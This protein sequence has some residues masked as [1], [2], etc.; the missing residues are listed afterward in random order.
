MNT[1]LIAHSTNSEGLEHSLRSHLKNVSDVMAVFAENPLYED[2]FRLTGLLHDIGKYQIAFQKYLREGGKRGSVPHASLGASYAIN[3]KLY[4]SAF[5]INGHH[6]GLP[7]KA[8][9]QD[10]YAEFKEL[11]SASI[12]ESFLNDANIKEGDLKN[13]SLELENI[14]KELFIRFLFSALTDAD[15]LD[16]EKHFNQQLSDQRRA[17]DFNADFLIIKLKNELESKNKEGVINQLRNIVREY[18]VNHANM[19]T[20]FFSMTLPTGM[21]KTLASINWAL[22]HAKYNELKRIIIV[23]PFISIIDQ[24]ASEFKRIFGEDQILEHHSGFIE[25]E[26]NHNENKSESCSDDSNLKRLATENWDY[27]IIVT[28][29]VQF[30]ESLFANKPSRCRKVH[31]IANSVVIFDEVQTLPKNL[32][33]PTLSIMKNVQKVMNTSFLFCTATQ[34]AF[35][36]TDKFNGIDKIFSL[37]ENPEK[38]FE[39]TRRVRYTALNQYVP[40]GLTEL[41]DHILDRKVSALA[42]FNTKKQALLFYKEIQGRT[43]FK[44]FHLSTSMYPAHRKKVIESIRESLRNNE[45]I[46]VSSTQLIEAGVDFDFPCVAREISP[47]ESIIQSAGR[48]NREGR[49]KEPG[50]A[51]IFKLKD[52]GA[53][54][55]QYRSLAEFAN[56]LYKEKEDLLCK[57]ELFGEYYSKAL[58]LLIEPDKLKIEDDRLNFRF[59]TVAE[60]YRLIDDNTV[61]VFILCNES[62]DLYE[63]IHHKPVLSR[64]DYRLMQ[65]YSVQF[66]EKFLKDNIDKIGKES[67]GY[68]VWHGEYNEDYGVTTD[69]QLLIL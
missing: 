31:N 50:E 30:F 69:N 57:H 5:A 22:E 8:D 43:G 11:Q 34:P 32:V 12:W 55:N 51:I 49:M 3:Y 37:V 54:N 33:I 17:P 65:Q 60:K 10:D 9:L 19:P 68:W 24:T 15:W 16:T 25:D 48:C 35:E 29:S 53:P 58:N 45:M 6:K 26:E 7:D 4:E 20:G 39:A 21:G 64:S 56:T 18:A 63:R 42:V 41:A 67:Q 62:R 28:T 59:K 38:I 23:L 36:R 13:K 27:P 14:E 1:Q 61:P 44:T 52:A 47:M 66:F 46:L 2:I 40:I